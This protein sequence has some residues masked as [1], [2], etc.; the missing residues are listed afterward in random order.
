MGEKD[1]RTQQIVG[2]PLRF[3]STS[4]AP[5][6][7]MGSIASLC[8]L[9]PLWQERSL[10]ILVGLAS[11]DPP[12]PVKTQAPRPKSYW[13]GGDQTPAFPFESDP[14]GLR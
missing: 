3:I 8:P 14:V 11:L 13:D 5:D 2:R 9:C 12:Y 7:W 10:R 1:G 6:S 4:V